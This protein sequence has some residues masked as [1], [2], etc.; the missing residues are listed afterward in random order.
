MNCFK[1]FCLLSV[2]FFIL[3][4][5][6]NTNSIFAQT[7]RALIIGLGEQQ[8]QTWSKINGDTDLQYVEEMLHNAKYENICSLINKDATKKNIVKVFRTLADDCNVGDIVYIHFSGHGQ[9]MKDANGDESD[10][11]DECWIP[12]DAYK[13]PCSKDYGEKHLSDD[14]INILLKEIKNKI[15]EEGK[16]LVVVDACHSGDSS[17]GNSDDEMIRGVSEVFNTVIEKI[18]RKMLVSSS[19]EQ[20]ESCNDELWITISACKSNQVN[21]ELKSPAVGKLTY[22]LFQML[23]NGMSFDNFSF[24]RE[25]KQFVNNN[26]SKSPQT[27]VITGET[28]KFNII[29]ILR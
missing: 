19:M 6:L 29:D 4:I 5:L 16:I 14:E 23:R 2:F 3:H 28:N 1:Q 25:I 8:D 22:A 21:T 20:S 13:I 11:L 17:R 9:Q 15:G 12:Y 18:K 10:G 27:P 26:S 24:E 7:K